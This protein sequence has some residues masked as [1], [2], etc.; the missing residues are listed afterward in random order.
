MNQLAAEVSPEYNKKKWIL[1]PL[2]VLSIFA[3]S[4]GVFFLIQTLFSGPLATSMEAL[5][6]NP[7]IM[8]ITG[9]P[10]E[11]SWFVAGATE[12][13]GNQGSSNLSFTVSGPKADVEVQSILEKDIEGWR[14]LSG[15]AKTQEGNIIDFTP[16]E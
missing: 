15:K 1:I 2:L 4:S 13:S 9:Q 3:I 16:S 6:Q 14:I 8:S 12:I 11:S 5:K 7:E 10:I